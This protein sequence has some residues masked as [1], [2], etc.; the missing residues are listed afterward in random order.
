MFCQLTAIHIES[1]DAYAVQFNYFVPPTQRC[2]QEEEHIIIKA[3]FKHTSGQSE[4]KVK[5]LLITSIFTH[6][7]LSYLSQVS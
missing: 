6:V 1:L 7:I 5:L 3:A 2:S 4:A